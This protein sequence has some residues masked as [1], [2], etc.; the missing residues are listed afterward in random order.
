MYGKAFVNV[1]TKYYCIH[2]KGPYMITEKAG[3][4]SGFSIIYSVTLRTVTAVFTPADQSKFSPFVLMTFLYQSKESFLNL[5]RVPDP[6][7]LRST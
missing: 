2:H 4:I 1:L 7:L 3:M 6:S 5:S